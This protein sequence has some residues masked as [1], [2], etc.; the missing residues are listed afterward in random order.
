M[1]LFISLWLC[2][3]LVSLVKDTDWNS[4]QLKL[5][6]NLMIILYAH[7]FGYKPIK[8]S[9]KWKYYSIKDI[10]IYHIDTTNLVLSKCDEAN[11]HGPK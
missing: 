2:L 4:Q 3:K 9:I 1:V 11:M 5:L 10:F 8:K 6:I 7:F